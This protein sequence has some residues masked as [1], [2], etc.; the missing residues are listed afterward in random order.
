M[1]ALRL[2]YR[3]ISVSIQEEM[4]YRANFFI[5]LLHSMLNLATGVAGMI[6]IFGQ[7][8]NIHGWDFPSVLALLGVYLLLDALRGFFISP[9]LDALVGVEGEVA[10]GRFDFILLRPL[11]VQFH[12]SFRRWKLFS[13]LD[14]V[15]AL[16]V[17]GT[18]IAQLQ[19]KPGMTEW[20][21]FL[22]VLAASVTTLYA[23]LLA[24]TS[25]AFWS[26]GFM[27]NWMFDSVFQMA[28]YPVELYP[29]WLRLLLTWVVPLGVM[30]SIPARALNASLSPAA[31][32]GSLLLSLALLLLASRLFRHGVSR[33]ASASS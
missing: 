29:A 22:L 13:V 12:V 17:L 9:G 32:A 3:F 25:L 5:H 23:I 19:Q 20:L 7:V 26:P 33:Y 2:V 31:L 11:D 4:A 1:R 28:R 15:L 8:E 18:A 6:I 30:T 21:S 10:D 16:A 24:F 14:L 27:F